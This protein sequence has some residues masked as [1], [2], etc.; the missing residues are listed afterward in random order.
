MK[1]LQVNCLNC[2]KIP[3]SKLEQY[4]VY[5]LIILEFFLSRESFIDGVRNNLIIKI[6]INE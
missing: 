5:D 1:V 2:T 3:S 4:A 6:K